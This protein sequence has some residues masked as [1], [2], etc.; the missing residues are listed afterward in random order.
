MNNHI[1]NNGQGMHMPMSTDELKVEMQFYEKSCH[2]FVEIKPK[3]A[4][5]LETEWWDKEWKE[6]KGV[7]EHDDADW[8]WKDGETWEEKSE[9]DD[10]EEVDH[11]KEEKEKK[12]KD[13]DHDKQ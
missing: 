9:E 8:D 3:A 4:E 6:H 2:F 11:K 1:L 7:K 10:K 13:H 12:K 5:F